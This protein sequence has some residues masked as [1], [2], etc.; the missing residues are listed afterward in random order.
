MQYFFFDYTYILI[1]I[2]YVITLWAQIK[3]KSTYSKYSRVS[4]RAGLSGADAAYAVLRSGG[5]ENVRIEGIPGELTDHYDPR[6]N[7]IRLS[8]GVFG[9]STVAAA[10]VAAHEAGHA[11]QYA[12]SYAPIKL[13]TAIIPV[14][15]V[16]SRLA[17]PLFFVGLILSSYAGMENGTG[18]FLMNLGIAAFS[19]AVLFQLVTLP[20]E[21][22]ASRRALAALRADGRF[23]DEEL[24]GAKKVLT[25]AAL[26]YVAALA[27][28]LLQLFRLLLIAAS[29]SRRD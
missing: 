2:A 8:E 14:C 6:G 16:A 1:I 18:V 3:V 12:Q 11:L 15:N 19:I 21:L 17:W 26:T 24:A 27:S 4:N 5:A 10:G 22:N 28:S 29:R 9:Q 13:R 25:A 23:T 20:V 7:V